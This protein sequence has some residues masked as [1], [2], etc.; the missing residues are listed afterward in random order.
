MQGVVG[1][2]QIKAA[3][4]NV[5]SVVDTRLAQ[6]LGANMQYVLSVIMLLALMGS[7]ALLVGL[8]YFSEGVIKSSSTS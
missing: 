6:K 8:V 3:E 2:I 1:L 5:A 7:F 4:A